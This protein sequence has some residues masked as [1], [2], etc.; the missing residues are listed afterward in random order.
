MKIKKHIEEV[1]KYNKNISFDD[2]LNVE[3]KYT[4]QNH[5]KNLF[6]T[7]QLKFV[8]NDSTFDVSINT[9]RYIWDRFKTS[10]NICDYYLLCI[11]LCDIEYKMLSDK[12]NLYSA[13]NDD[14]NDDETNYHLFLI[15]MDN[16]TYTYLGYEYEERWV[17]DNI[18]KTFIEQFYPNFDRID[19]PINLTDKERNPITVKQFEDTI[20]PKMD[21]F[22]TKRDD[23]K[24]YSF[25]TLENSNITYYIEKLS[26]KQ[27]PK[28]YKSLQRIH[29]LYQMYK[30]SQIHLPQID[31][32]KQITINGENISRTENS[33]NIQSID[34]WGDFLSR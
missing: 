33:D 18:Y 13:Q 10:D 9:F 32:D 12:H 6:I 27:Y 15:N 22:A 5:I 26:H 30:Y 25:M 17:I 29:L 16:M 2:L 19:K 14:E 8:G 31:G 7:N 3:L 23:D 28:V 34:L 21:F 1:Y 11:D 24:N 4:L 20:F